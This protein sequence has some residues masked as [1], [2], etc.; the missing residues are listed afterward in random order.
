MNVV[1]NID[2]ARVLGALI[3]KQITTPDYYPLTLH[4]LVAACNQKNNRHP[5]M[6]LDEKAVVRAL[7]GLRDKQLA[8]EMASAGARV[9]KYSHNLAGRFVLSAPQTAILCELILR[10]PQT[11]GEL[12]VHGERLSAMESIEAVVA[13]LETMANYKDGPLVVKLSREIGSREC[14]YAHLLCGEVQVP[15]EARQPPPEPARLEVRAENERL[16]A[17]EAEVCALHKELDDVRQ[18]FNEF[19]AQFY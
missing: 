15:A 5:L 9:Q 6:S 18:Q 11:A 16:A 12:K 2:E 7:D 8:W 14:R 13:L 10:G 17:L 1:L 19:K 4:A 3:E